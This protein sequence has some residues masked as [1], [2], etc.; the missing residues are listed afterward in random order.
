MIKV[1]VKNFSGEKAGELELSEDVFGVKRKD[2]VIHQVYVSQYANQREILAHTKTRAERAGS[3]RKPWKQKGTGRARVGSV[4]SPLWRKGGITFGPT[5][6]RNFKKKVNKKM[7][8]LAIRMVLSGKLADKELV[9]I[10]KYDISDNKTKALAKGLAN[11]KI[12]G[13]AIVAFGKEEKEKMLASRNISKV[14]H[15][16]IENLN[17][18]DMLNSKYLVLSQEGV[19]FLEEKYKP[20]KVAVDK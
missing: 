8:L 19:K 20:V 5:L 16:F 17:V 1:D 15:A 10:D 9:I 3:G 4:R 2:S 13:S 7:N 11:L 14:G 6:L 18:Y 12:K